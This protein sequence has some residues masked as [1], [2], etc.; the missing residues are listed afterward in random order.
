MGVTTDDDI[1]SYATETEMTVHIGFLNLCMACASSIP[2][3]LD[4]FFLSCTH[5]KTKNNEREL[6]RNK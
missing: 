4:L 5:N 2:Y 1:S 6:V 3:N